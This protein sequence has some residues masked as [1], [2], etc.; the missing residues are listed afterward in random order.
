ML[1]HLIH[2]APVD[3]PQQIVD[4]SIAERDSTRR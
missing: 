2:G 3:E 4:F 1:I